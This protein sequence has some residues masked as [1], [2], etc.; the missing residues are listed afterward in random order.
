MQRGRLCL[1]V[2]LVITCFYAIGKM[3]FLINPASA[4][5][6]K[7]RRFFSPSIQGIALPS[8]TVNTHGTPLNRQP[9]EAFVTFSNNRP[10]YLALLAT[11]LDS[12]H[13]FSTRPVIVYGVDVDVDIDLTKYPRVI[14]QRIDGRDCGPSIYF[15]KIKA[16][17]DSGV[18]YGVQL[19]ADSIVNWNIDVLFDVVR[20]WPYALPLA[21]RHPTDPVN[22]ER[23]L[24]IFNLTL[25]SRTTPY[26]H[27]HFLWNYRS[28][29]FWRTALE[30]MQRGHFVGANYDETGINILLWEAKANHTLCKTDPYFT[31]FSAYETQQQTCNEFC[32]TAFV[33][34]HGSKRA[35]DLRALFQQVKKRVGSPYIQTTD[36][37]FHHLNETRYTCCYPDSRPSPIHPLICE[38]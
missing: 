18:D 1:I 19:E 20:R 23:F 38:H 17:V 22:Y 21:P 13:E 25:N 29:P 36:H 15:C 35:E 16:I 26:I 34:F 7:I 33:V 27:A 32:H 11:L 10:Q 4:V 6:G 9:R 37:G 24:P 31:Y 5:H 12:V 3:H 30:L 14:K 28:Y 8:S 2:L